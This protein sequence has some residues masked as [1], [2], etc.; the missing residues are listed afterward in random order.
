MF[1][2]KTKFFLKPYLGEEV[3]GLVDLLLH[4]VVSRLVEVGRDDLRSNVVE[5]VCGLEK[6]RILGL[7]SKR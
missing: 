4:L 5:V 3:S 2:W 7:I 6:K 1:L